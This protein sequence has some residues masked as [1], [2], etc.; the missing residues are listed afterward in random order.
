MKFMANRLLLLGLVCSLT[1]PVAWAQNPAGTEFQ[2]NSYTTNSQRGAAVAS[3][4]NGNF[5]VVWQ[6]DGQDGSSYGVFGQRFNAA[7]IP[8]GSEFQVNSYTTGYQTSPSVTSAANGNFV[9]VWNSPGQDGSG[10]G[11]F[12]Q[13]FDASGI[14][15]GSEFQ[16]NSYTTGIQ[17]VPSVASDANGNFVVVWQSAD[18]DGGSYGVFGQRFNAAGLPQG[19]EFQVNSYTT[20]N[21]ANPAVAADG[22]GNFVVVWNSSGQDG[23]NDGVF[24]QRFAASGLPQGSEFQVNSYTTG[25]QTNAEVASAGNGDFF[26]VWSSDSQ[27]G[28][29]SGVFGQRFNT[30]GIPLGTE[31]QVNSYTTGDQNNLAMASD[32]DGN[33]VVVWTSSPQD[34][35]YLGVFGQR[36]GASGLPLGSEFQVNSYTTDNQTTPSVASAANGSFVV[37]WSS[38]SQ[39]GSSDGIFGQRFGIDRLTVSK[40]GTGT[41]TVTSSPPGINCGADCAETYNHGTSVTLSA[42]ADPSSTFASWGGGGCTGSG[43]CTVSVMGAVAVTATFAYGPL[44]TDDPLQSAT[45]P[46]KVIHFAELRQPVNALRA[47]AGLAAAT[48]TDVT[49]TA[50]V[51][52]VKAVHLTELRAALNAVYVAASR[53]VPTYTHAAITG[54]VT[55][56]TAVD[57]AELRAAILAIW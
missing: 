28:S 54:G 55:V 12:G 10:I 41:G 34:G 20:S 25:H 57:I 29:S 9:V 53:T 48:W 27:D 49:L 40:A 1:C 8:Q 32:A 2:V 30:S 4:A 50:G 21:Q 42:A 17:K 6:S 36:F 35:S 11:V 16:V 22:D 24:G 14:P 38:N 46:V 13:R 3:D 31:F 52:P 39:D 51:T 5:V 26:V 33:F 45:T 23:N 19:S 47:R 7:G 43:T 44:F 37:V 15:L 56:I 18:Q